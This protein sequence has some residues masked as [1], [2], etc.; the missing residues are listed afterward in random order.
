MK[1]KYTYS[2]TPIYTDQ[3]VYT[4]SKNSSQTFWLFRPPFKENPEINDTS[5]E[6]PNTQLIESE[7]KL[8]VASF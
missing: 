4:Y 8:V 5:F 2:E 1:R 3:H 6:S 7:L